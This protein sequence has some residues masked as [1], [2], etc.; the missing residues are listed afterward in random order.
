MR[1]FKTTRTR[2][3]EKFS[4]VLDREE[5]LQAINNELAAQG[6]KRIPEDAY[7]FITVPGGGDWSNT[8]LD[9]AEHHLEILWTVESGDDQ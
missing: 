2:I 4:A 7:L 1:K 8:Q 5:L 6:E 9:L 3:T